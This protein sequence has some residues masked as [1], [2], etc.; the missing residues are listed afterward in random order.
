MA[1]P[2]TTG[3]LA[4]WMNGE[5]VGIW[6]LRS[7]NAHVFAYERGW[8]ASPTSRPI[9]LSM[10]LRAAEAPYTG[11]VVEAFFDNLLPD[12]QAIRQRI[13]A[14]F[15]TTSSR[16]F[17]LLAQIGRDCV[18]AIQLLAVGRE[19]EGVDRISG[20]PMDTAA[21]A[22]W[23]RATPSLAGIGRQDDDDFRISLAGAQE[24]TALLWHRG[25]WH[26]PRGA[27]PSTHIFKLPMG[28]VGNM[29]ADFRSSVENEWLCARIVGAYGLAVAD[30]RIEAFEDQKALVVTRF[31]RRLAA[32]NT[33]WLR[34][35]QEDL[36]QA[37]ATP[38]AI[39][40]ESDGG[41]GI[42]RAMDLLLGSAN[43]AADRET[44]FKTQL[45]FWML[46]ATDGHAKNFSVHIESGG[47]YR[48]TPLYDI[49]SAYPILGHGA[50][51]LAPERAR[52][53]MAAISKNRHYE[54]SKILPRH[55]DAT[56][57]RCGLSEQRAQEIR[58]ELAA[59]TASVVA[60]VQSELPPGFPDQLA[61]L[62]FLGL[63][64]A[65]A[66]LS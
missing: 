16:A 43:A 13:Q 27:T 61:E 58:A 47:R 40:Y 24:K 62:V 29:Q 10:P 39:K 51:L 3:Q 44:F 22:A 15:G 7:G 55:W 37:T 50:N 18:G 21:V 1:R 49:L 38:P 23:L 36:C 53:A 19:P 25:Q 34:L 17:D 52:M 28:R 65:A 31:D 41:P 33:H 8:L 56:A 9:S 30:C 59:S 14:R 2:R 42:V 46:C 63:A 48:L 54:W 4:V 11:E 5:R 45:V 32:A 20:E 64:Q 57:K 6:S 12:S 35:P 60:Q 66:R 26:R